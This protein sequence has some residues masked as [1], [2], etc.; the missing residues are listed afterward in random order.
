MREG[1]S[2]KLFAIFSDCIKQFAFKSTFRWESFN[3]DLKHWNHVWM[4]RIVPAEKEY[5]NVWVIISA[6]YTQPSRGVQFH[7]LPP[8]L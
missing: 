5:T 4:Y 7:S 8:M 3:V 1:N 6:I 2:D